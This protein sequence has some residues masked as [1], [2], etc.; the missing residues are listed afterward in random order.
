MGEHYFTSKPGTPHNV[1]LLEFQ[2]RGQTLRF[3]TDAGV[4]SRERVDYGSEVLLKALPPLQ[5]KVLDLGCGYGALGVTLAKLNPEAQVTMVDVNERAAELAAKNL[6]LNQ[7][8]NARVLVSDGFA[9]VTGTYDY[10]IS[11]PP[12]RAGKKVFYPWFEAAP[13]FLNPRG[14][15]CIVIQKK[16]G[17][18]SA[19]AKFKEIFGNCSALDKSG[20]YWILRSIL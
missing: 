14:C 3:Y 13:S 18:P 4:F 11:N 5:G 12:I 20:G 17:A 19:E 1:K 15:L 8:N 10:I 7:V 2:F 16:Q 6:E 9:N